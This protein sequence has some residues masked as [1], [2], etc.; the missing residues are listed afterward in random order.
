MAA[1]TILVTKTLDRIKTI[2]TGISGIGASRVFQG[3]RRFA[4]SENLEN[5]IAALTA[6]TQGYFFFWFKGGGGGVEGGAYDGGHTF[7]VGGVL[8]VNLP[9]DTTTDENSAIELAES[10]KDALL[11]MDSYST[12]E[13]KPKEIL[14]GLDA[15]ETVRNRG[16]LAFGFGGG[17]N[18]VGQMTFWGGC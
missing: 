14:Y 12:G 10:L 15:L 4:D 2:A 1:G 8:L 5:L 18:G 9:K 13:G 3:Y 6:E 16:I 11:V 7:S 17:R